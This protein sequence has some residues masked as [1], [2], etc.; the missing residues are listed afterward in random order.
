[1]AEALE[2]AKSLALEAGGIIANNLSVGKQV[3]FKGVVDPVTSI[4]R[5]CEDLI[6]AG[7]RDAFPA[8][9]IV[10]EETGG[11]ATESGPCWY[12]DPI[13]GTCNFVHSL[14]HCAVSIAQ[15][16]DGRPQVA[17]VYDP[18][19]NELYEAQNGDGARCNGNGI[20][21]SSSA[22]LDR[23]LLVTG[24]PYDRRDKSAFYLAYFEAFLC[25]A[26]DLRR[27]GSA[28]LDL[29]WV[30]CGRFE[31]F[32]E[33]GLQPWDTAAGWLILREAGGTVTDFRGHGYDPSG[34]SILASNG[35]IHQQCLEVL[36]TVSAA[37][38]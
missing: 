17:V 6:L 23:S 33:W 18:S 3:D 32:F 38:R 19:R 37:E 36:H 35:L 7:L 27:L 11:R 14:P 20:R 28:A 25:R 9:G 2:I 12:V 13:D 8:H 31:G 30:A 15:F 10:A 5:Q 1:M 34:R 26:Q 22:R 16:V 24:F 21:V 4:D 29:C